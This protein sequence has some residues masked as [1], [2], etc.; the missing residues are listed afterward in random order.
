MKQKQ[1]Q[2]CLCKH[3]K[4]ALKQDYLL[5]LFTLKDD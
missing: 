3:F 5:V 2:F 4:E 1:L